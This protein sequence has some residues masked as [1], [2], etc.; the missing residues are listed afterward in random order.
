MKTIV[1]KNKLKSITSFLALNIALLTFFLSS[2]IYFDIEKN[3]L[4]KPDTFT[5]NFNAEQT[6]NAGTV[7]AGTINGS[8][9]FLGSDGKLHTWGKNSSGELGLGPVRNLSQPAWVVIGD[10]PFLNPEFKYFTMVDKVDWRPG[11]T[12]GEILVN[13]YAITTNGELYVWGDNSSGQIGNGQRNDD[14]IAKPELIDV[15]DNEADNIVKA[16]GS[17]GSSFA[18]T[19]DGDL[20]M[21][22]NNNNG[23]L[24]TGDKLNLYEPTLV[25]FFNDKKV[26]DAGFSG[27]SAWALTDQGE[28][29]TWGDNEFGQL[30][31]TNFDDQL[32]PYLVNQN[33]TN[34][35]EKV[36]SA[37]SSEYLYSFADL[38]VSSYA[39]T[40][41]GNLYA[42]GDNKFGQIGN[43][44]TSNVN[45]PYLVN[46]N[47]NSEKINEAKIDTTSYAITESGKLYLWGNNNYKQINSTSSNVLDPVQISSNN[48]IVSV[49]SSSRNTSY[50]T[51][52][53]D[54]YILGDNTY[55]Q[56]GNN[57][58]NPE[59]NW[60]KHNLTTKKEKV[61]TGGVTNSNTSFLVTDSGKEYKIYFWGQ[62]NY[63]QVGNSNFSNATSPQLILN[64]TY[65]FTL[66]TGAIVGIVIGS[67]AF[68]ALVV[69]SSWAF[70]YFKKVKK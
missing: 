29:Y 17:Q 67:V 44:T 68:V 56:L 11:P 22:G 25:N 53:G 64:Y 18:L 36:I 52:N 66:S 49:S 19:T 61:V 33:F 60:V 1:N 45:A 35:E 48:N 26:V 14:G 23:Q 58:L 40:N 50:I 63:G 41:Q 20:Y 3:E 69:G 57:S 30:G 39:L 21:W 32:D 34:N 15:I 16:G 24:G 46:S 42:W 7:N 8:S 51:N 27:F 47:L 70:Y 12:S 62:N 5:T 37:G 4:L 31:T 6:I 2:F 10:E 28:L 55:G 13:S 65:D 38:N 54:F 59:S 43:K 9:Y